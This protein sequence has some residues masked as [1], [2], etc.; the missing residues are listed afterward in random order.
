MTPQLVL[1]LP[2]DVRAIARAVDFVVSRC[3]AVDSD[4]RKVRLNLRVGLTEAL[5]NAM[6]YGNGRDP[7]KRVR[8]EIGWDGE[9]VILRVSDEGRGFDPTRVPDPTAATNLWKVGGRGLFL[10]RQLMDEVHF[11]DAGNSVTMVLR[12]RQC[13]ANGPGV[14]A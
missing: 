7:A 12:C 4:P 8:V 1:E 10:M 6:L 5:S 9:C 11:N 13:P 3:Q 14:D 2:N